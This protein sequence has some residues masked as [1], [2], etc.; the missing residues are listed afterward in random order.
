MCGAA[1]IAREVMGRFT[2]GVKQSDAGGTWYN[3]PERKSVA[4]KNG[5]IITAWKKDEYSFEGRY[6]YSQ[7]LKA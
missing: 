3:V 5:T 4:M 6:I 1:K 2:V 7:H